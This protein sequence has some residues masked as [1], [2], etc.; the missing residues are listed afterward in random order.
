MHPGCDEHSQHQW[1]EQSSMVLHQYAVD[2]KAGRVGQARPGT[3]LITIGRK[4]RASTTHR[5][6]TNSHSSGA[7]LRSRSLAFL[8]VLSRRHVDLRLHASAAAPTNAPPMAKS[9]KARA[10][11]AVVCHPP[12]LSPTCSNG[13][14]VTVSRIDERRRQGRIQLQDG[15]TFPEN[16]KQ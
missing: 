11:K 13:E 15:R 8:L 12:K 9:C 16:Y 14:L 2:H 1:F 6:R 5:R 7:T 3:R 4:R 10:S